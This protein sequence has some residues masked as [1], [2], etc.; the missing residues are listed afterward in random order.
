M[1]DF[2]INNSATCSSQLW[3]QIIDFSGIFESAGCFCTSRCKSWLVFGHL[4]SALCCVE[5]FLSPS[6]PSKLEPYVTED[7]FVDL[8][9]TSNSSRALSC[10]RP[11][12]LF[13]ITPLAFCKYSVLLGGNFPSEAAKAADPADKDKRIK[14]ATGNLSVFSCNVSN[15]GEQMEQLIVCGLI[16]SQMPVVVHCSTGWLDTLSLPAPLLFQRSLWCLLL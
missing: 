16:V 15:A 1:V 12:T 4:L 2:F 5:L 13:F 9:H 7:L 8:L 14:Q 10:G 3:C 11:M 6:F